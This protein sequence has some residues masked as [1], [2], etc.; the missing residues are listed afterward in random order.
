MNYGEYP[1]ISVS[2][3]RNICVASNSEIALAHRL[4]FIRSDEESAEVW[5]KLNLES[6][7]SFSLEYYEKNDSKFNSKYF[8]LLL[9]NLYEQWFLISH[10]RAALESLVLEFQGSDAILVGDGML[11]ALTAGISEP[12]PLSGP[13]DMDDYRTKLQIWVWLSSYVMELC[14]G[15]FLR[16][17][18]SKS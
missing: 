11:P 7:S 5:R 6:F 10:P 18:E 15:E 4:G 16:S 13:S 8:C 12:D 2:R 14:E 3:V 9:I 1:K 17:L